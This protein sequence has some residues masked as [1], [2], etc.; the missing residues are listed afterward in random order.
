MQWRSVDAL[1]WAGTRKEKKEEEK[2]KEEAGWRT[3][4]ARGERVPPR[5]ST[6]SASVCVCRFTGGVRHQPT[7][8]RHSRPR[9][10]PSHRWS[11]HLSPADAATISG[12]SQRK[13]PS[14]SP[15][16]MSTRPWRWGSRRVYRFCKIGGRPQ[17][18]QWGQ[19]QTSRSEEREPC[20]VK[21]RKWASHHL[22]VSV[23][24]CV[25]VCVCASWFAPPQA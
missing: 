15:P 21:E 18:H 3:H 14:A 25:C 23:S 12:D 2:E 24:V 16:C 22:W 20:R 10:D 13:T 7:R 8:G 1:Q 4:S 5:S 17:R 9:C 19:R 6:R 11:R